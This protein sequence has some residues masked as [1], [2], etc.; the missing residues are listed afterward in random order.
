MTTQ[1]ESQGSMGQTLLW[2]GVAAVVI[3][4]VAY[5]SM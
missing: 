5:F 1:T 3:L 4:V 2:L